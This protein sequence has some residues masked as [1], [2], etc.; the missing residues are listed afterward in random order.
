MIRSYVAL[1]DPERVGLPVSVFVTVELQTQTDE[2]L[3]SFERAVADCPEVMECYVMTGTS[4]YLLRVVTA[5][6]GAYE[7]FLRTKLTRM[8]G[9]ALDQVGVRAETGDLPH[10]PADQGP[11]GAEMSGA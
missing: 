6:L 9:V 4:D 8:P 3:V 10:Q 11:A 2:H 5:D 1:L 7:A